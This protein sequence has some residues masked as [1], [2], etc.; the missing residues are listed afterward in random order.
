MNYAALDFLLSQKLWL[1]IFGGFVLLGTIYSIFDMKK[2]GKENDKKGS[3]PLKEEKY[4][5]NN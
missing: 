5:E 4:Y 3:A 1:V 2:G